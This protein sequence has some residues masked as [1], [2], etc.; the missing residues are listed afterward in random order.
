MH[1]RGHCGVGGG[2]VTRL[3]ETE[4]TPRPRDLGPE[5][6]WRLLALLGALLAALLAALLGALLAALLLDP[7]L[8]GDQQRGQGDWG[9]C[10]T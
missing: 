10:G 6:D 1:Y 2:L 7:P 4:L 5:L 9:H 3:L 8:E